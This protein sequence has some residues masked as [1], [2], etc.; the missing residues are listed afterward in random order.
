MQDHLTLFFWLHL[1]L[2]KITTNLRFIIDLIKKIVNYNFIVRLYSDMVKSR[3][4]E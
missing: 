4:L 1:T 2:F 3:K